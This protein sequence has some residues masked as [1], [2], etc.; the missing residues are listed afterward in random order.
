[1]T[2]NKSTKRALLSAVLSMIICVSMLIGTTFAWFTDNTSTAVN[3]VQAGTLDIELQYQKEDG[4]W[5]NA[6]GITLGFKKNA[7]TPVGEQVLWEPGC[8]YEL[9]A[10]K[11][12]NKGTLAVKYKIV[13]NGI[14]GDAKLNEV[15]DWTYNNA[16]LQSEGS[17]LAGKETEAITIKGHMQEAAGNEYQGL[18]IDGIGITVYA[19]QL[20]HEYDSFGNQYDD[21]ADYDGEISNAYSLEAAL[22][23]GGT[24]K[25]ISNIA[26]DKTLTVTEDAAVNIDLN[27]KT[28]TGNIEINGGELTV[29][30]GAIVNDNAD[31]SG[32]QNNGGTLVLN[33]V[34]ISSARHGVRV[35]GG[36]VTINGGIYKVDPNSKKTLHALNVSDGATVTINGG[37][38]IGPK[39]TMA[40]SGAAVNVQAGSTVIIKGGNFSKGLN[41]TLASKGTLTVCGGTFDQDPSAYVATGYKA[42]ALNGVYIVVSN[43]SAVATDNTELKD[44]LSSGTTDVVLGTGT[45]TIPA[46]AQNK[47]LT[48]TGTKDTIINIQKVDT[49]AGGADMTFKGVTIQ[50]QTNGNYAG[51]GNGANVHFVDCTINGKISLYGKVASF[52]N[53]VFNNQHDYAIWTWGGE[54]V[55]FIGCTFN[56]GGKALLVYGEYRTADINIKDC[57]FNDDG[58]LD[59]AKAA[60]EIGSDRATDN[61]NITISNI[62]V[63]GFAVNS[64]GLSTNSKI[65]ANKNSMPKDRLNVVIDGVDVY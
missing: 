64:E 59:T 31:V 18:T 63:N 8:T 10:V 20:A 40:D 34:D 56:S 26:L 32:I 4:S 17:L 51:W 15:I 2:N 22:T 47:T 52:E 35:E 38:F 45:Y 43:D 54:D 50:G 1:M 42:A 41:N 9:P 13:I 14:D 48:I 24:Y 25:L 65:W 53:C 36:N 62:T 44:A 6:E 28:V 27:K 39:G 61:Y 16:A 29:N 46:S 5:A 7:S 11:V 19:T 37:T 58:T 55:D 60:V 21:G 33:D 12:V 23:N 3:S 49:N 57:E 30:N